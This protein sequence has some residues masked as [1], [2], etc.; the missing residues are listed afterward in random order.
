[1][2]I[3]TLSRMGKWGNHVDAALHPKQIFELSVDFMSMMPKHVKMWPQML[4]N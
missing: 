2:T 3:S 1:M 4:R